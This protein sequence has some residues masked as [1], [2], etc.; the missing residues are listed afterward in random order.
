MSTEKALRP[1]LI[2]IA[3]I[4]VFFVGAYVG[5]RND[6]FGNS[7]SDLFGGGDAPVTS[8]AL[9]VIDDNYFQAPDHADLENASV[10]GMVKQLRAKYKDRFSHYF[11]PKAYARFQEVLTGRFSGVGMAVN[12]VPRGLR[13]ADVFDGSPAQRAG[14]L[15]G[16][17]ITRVDGR[18]IAGKD[19]D[20]VVSDIKGPAGTKV[21]V[22]V[23]KPSGK[24]R[25]IEL[26]REEITAPAVEGH[27]RKAVGVPVAYIQIS[28]FSEAMSK[29]LRDEVERLYRRGAEGIVIDL[30]GNGG[31]SLD[32]AVLSSSLFVEDGVIVSIEGRT[33]PKQVFDA[34]GDALPAK[35]MVVLIN[36]DTASASEIMTAALSQAGLAEVLGEKSFGKGTF[37]QVV[38][39]ENGGALDLTVGEYLT[40]DGTSINHIGIK[41]DI[42]APDRPATKV[43]EGLRKALST[44]GADLR[45]QQN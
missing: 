24:R 26:T 6:S 11:D 18:S 35:P 19:A 28:T 17:L 10:G 14:I 4:A 33:Q 20:L 9:G 37:Q 36:R 15:P 21:T 25:Q 3:L 12:E 27:L 2:A 40:R 22:T 7:V 5:N 1:F 29:Q 41:P 45:G 32:E 44:L 30:R 8:E 43:D 42:K 16:D 34:V 38:D 39:L 23:V 13:I 31:G